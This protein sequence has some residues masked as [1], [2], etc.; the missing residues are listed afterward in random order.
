MRIVRLSAAALFLL[1]GLVLAVP[2]AALPPQC[3]VSCRCTSKCT[4]LCAIGG[5]VTNC[6]V[7]G[8]CVGQ[9]FA[10]ADKTSDLDSLRNAIFAEASPESDQSVP[11]VAMK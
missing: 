10:A 5:S 7:W 9:C 8:T 1:I 3:E 11:V 2:L 4:Q 6:G